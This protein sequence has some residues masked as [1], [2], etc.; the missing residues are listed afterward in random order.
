MLVHIKGHLGKWRHRDAAVCFKVLPQGKGATMQLFNWRIGASLLLAVLVGVVVGA[1]PSTQSATARLA[2]L[3]KEVDSLR[4]SV[5]DLTLKVGSM[6][7]TQCRCVTPPSTKT[8]SSPSGPDSMKWIKVTRIDQQEL[9]LSEIA[10]IEKK[11]QDAQEALDQVADRIEEEK[12]INK[13]IADLRRVY[14]P[15]GIPSSGPEFERWQFEQKK[16][17]DTLKDLA[18]TARNEA[19]ELRGQATRLEREIKEMERS[20]EYDIRGEGPDGEVIVTTTIPT[21]RT[22]SR[23]SIGQCITWEGGRGP[24]GDQGE[25]TWHAQSIKTIDCGEVVG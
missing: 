9:S 17:R 18:V 7:D 20:R 22:A 24:R 11:R 2:T 14:P 6:E 25:E 19:K 21:R 4:R 10:E 23:I 3:E 5:A 13:E 16:K 8:A 12:K 1:G 15:R